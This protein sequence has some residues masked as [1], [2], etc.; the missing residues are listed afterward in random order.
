MNITIHV[1]R[2]TVKRLTHMLQLAFQAGHVPQIKRLRALRLLADAHP[3]ETVAERVGVWKQTM[4]HWV[5]ALLLHRWARLY[6]RRSPGRPATLSTTQKQ[7][8][9]DLLAAGPEAAGYPSG[10]WNT[11]LIQDRIWRAFQRQYNPHDV[12]TLLR[13]V[14]F[15]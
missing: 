9:C 2:H 6:P 10:C 11:A 14:G 4:Y 3:V 8:V 15:S 1:G 7:R 5:H 12:A 13:N